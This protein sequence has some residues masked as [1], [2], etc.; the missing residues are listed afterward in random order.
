MMR[1]FTV[2]DAEQRSPQWFEA[3]CGR[4]T[5]SKAHVVFMD[6]ESA[7]RRDYALQLA[8]ERINRLPQPEPY[9]SAEM[10]RGI[11]KEPEARTEVE[12]H[13][14]LFI[15]QTGFLAHNK[16]PIGISLDGDAD[17]FKTTVELKCPKSIT[18]LGYLRAKALPAEYRA[19]VMHGLYITGASE[20]VFASYDDRMPEGLEL[21]CKPVKAQDLPIEK[22]ETALLKFL[23]EV[24]DTAIE[25]KLLQRGKL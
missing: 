9:V 1:P 5:G 18:H 12:V 23:D 16:L 17:D 11:E 20:A 24:E 4:V 3:R 2:I 10:K 21:F 6:K 13:T 14:G 22:Y 15:R 19:Q 7:G 8:L 25:L